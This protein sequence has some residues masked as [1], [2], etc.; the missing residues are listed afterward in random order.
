MSNVK[1]NKVTLSAGGIKRVIILLTKLYLAQWLLI[2]INTTNHN[3][4]ILHSYA[5]TYFNQ[6]RGR[7]EAVQ[8]KYIK[9]NNQNYNSNISYEV[10]LGSQS[11]L[12]HN[13]CQ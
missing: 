12:L 1:T 10:R 4:I 13:A 5:A 3:Y 6:Q 2:T 8:P 9:H 7:L 11:L